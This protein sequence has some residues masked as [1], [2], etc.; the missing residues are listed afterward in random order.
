GAA[1]RPREEWDILQWS[2]IPY[3]A[4]RKGF[5]FKATPRAA[6]TLR[7]ALASGPARVRV[8]VASSFSNAQERTLIADIPGRTL[9]NE[10]IVVAAHVQE[11][12]ANDNASGVATL[13]EM[14]RVL[15]EGI[16]KGKI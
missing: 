7:R 14:A 2:S 9:P 10:R 8:E 5:A 3:D 13:Q 11:P 16:T 6:T 4:V 12:G 15:A 1:V